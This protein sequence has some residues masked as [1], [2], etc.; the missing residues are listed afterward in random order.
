[1]LALMNVKLNLVGRNVENLLN[2]KK[3]SDPNKLASMQVLV[4]IGPAIYWASP[5]LI[6]MTIFNM[7]LLSI[8]N[9]NTDESTFAYSTY[10]LV[11]CGITGQ[12][13]NG[14]RFGDLAL[15]LSERVN[16]P[17]QVK[18][19]FNVYCFVNHW[20]YP[21]NNSFK[22]FQRTFQLGMENGDLEFAA[23]S[24]YLYC[25]HKF[26]SGYNLTS[27]D[28]EM[29]VY[30]KEIRQIKQYTSLNYNL[31]HWQATKC[32]RGESTDPMAFDGPVY[33]EKKKL[34]IHREAGDHT[35]LFK[36]HLLKLMLNC[37]YNKY[38]MALEHAR[39]GVKFEEAVTGMFVT[40]VF[41]Y[42]HG[43]ALA[44][45]IK[46][47]RDRQP[48]KRINKLKTKL[49]MFKKWAKNC[50]ENHE[51]RYLLLLAEYSSIVGNDNKA[52]TAYS[53]SIVIADKNGFIQ[54]KALASELAGRYYFGQNEKNLG[55]YY[56]TNSYQSYQAWGA[57]SK[58]QE[59]SQTYD[60]NNY[61]KKH[62]G[63]LADL[64]K[65]DTTESAL[66]KIDIN[67]VIKAST[68]IAEDINF[69][70]LKTRLMKILVEN[71]GAER[72]VLLIPEKGKLKVEKEWPESDEI[73]YAVTMVSL[74]EKTKTPIVSG[75]AEKDQTFGT[76]PHI[77]TEKVKSVLCF[78]LL[79]HGEL[80]A[81]VYLENNLVLGAFSEDRIEMLKL[82]SG[83]I[84]ISLKNSLLFT[85][86][87]KSYQQQVDLKQAYSRFVPMEFL[88][89]LGK[90]S[91][92][93]VEL[94]DQVQK[95]VTIMFIDIKDYTSISEK[96]TPKENF[97]FINACLRRVGPVIDTNEGF[98]CQFLGDGLMAIFKGEAQNAL[99]AAVLIQEEV[100]K[101]NSE[102]GNRLESNVSVG[103][104]LHTGKVML[105]IIGDSHRM[106]QNV[107]S[108]TVNISSRVQNLTRF[109][110]AS[111]IVTKQFLEKVPADVH[112]NF[113]KLGRVLVKGK[114][115]E[116]EI[117]ECLNGL[118]KEQYK[119]KM[120]TKN[121]FDEGLASYYKKEFSAAALKF[122][123]VKQINPNDKASLYFLERSAFYMTQGV[124][125]GWTGVD[126]MLHK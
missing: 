16:G 102:L 63:Q 79:H 71:V 120:E 40:P 48:G 124:P 55:Y 3:M 118:D 23:L 54:D 73:N 75:N 47:G 62:F 8:K 4:S 44:G 6:P 97:N 110:G 57:S 56:L 12:I 34:A 51:H 116:I 111:V 1:M 125:E 24:A 100:M 15:K 92:L 83:Q 59:L 28:E 122:D 45:H 7:L 17:N 90:D 13:R 60:L 14:N 52:K 50:P 94:G 126:I 101:F 84:A 108:D 58:C 33:Y 96:M 81:V 78:P 65:A 29:A 26:Y 10:G 95:E 68:A 109:Y 37:I 93:E 30:C 119:L 42:Y 91:I 43:L 106:D 104:G 20:K 69:E 105:G 35:A 99:T 38:E 77:I 41:H 123:Q 18:G 11:L 46:D 22:P 9:G 19:I 113:R 25:N 103:I 112:A 121:I 74:A 115:K 86:L 117:Y 76:D 66:H 27:L 39:E 82:L 49:K 72:G 32:L 36:Y 89:F 98:I 64:L 31:L 2:L 85:N 61:F 21:L 107:I 80:L 5:N 53:R 114:L 70:R 87:G 67:T 88:K